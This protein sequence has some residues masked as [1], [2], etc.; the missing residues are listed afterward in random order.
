LQEIKTKEFKVTTIGEPN[1]KALP[2]SEQAVFYSTLF[3]RIKELAE[4]GGK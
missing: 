4:K 2:E 3:H 1:I